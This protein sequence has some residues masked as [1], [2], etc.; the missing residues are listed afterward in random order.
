MA[1][2]RFRRTT[3]LMTEKHPNISMPQ[4]LVKLLIPASSKLSSSTSPKTAQKSV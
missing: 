4:N 3:M 1:M 2:R